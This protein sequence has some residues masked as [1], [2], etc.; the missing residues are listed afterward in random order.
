M[1]AGR[2]DSRVLALLLF[3]SRN[4]LKP[5]RERRCAAHGRCPRERG[6]LS[7]LDQGEGVDISKINGVTIA[8][9]QGA[10]T[11]TDLTIRTLLTLQGRFAPHRIVSLMRYP[12]APTHAG[13]GSTTPSF[14]GV[15]F[16]AHAPARLRRRPPS[17]AAAHSAGPGATAPSPFAVSLGFAPRA[18]SAAQWN[19]LLSRIGSL[20]QPKVATK[21]S[22][23]AI[24]D[25][26]SSASG[27]GSHGARH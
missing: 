3:L 24:R 2:V 9:H 7:A 17:S 27:S 15:D 26:G 14:I 1:I 16:H 5:T 23:S 8:G 18:S 6:V 4:G 12:G 21:P 25:P 19:Q 20:P 22:S 11:I 10:G 13:A